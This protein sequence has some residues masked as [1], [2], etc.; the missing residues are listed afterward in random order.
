MN[1]VELFLLGRTL[2]KIG[3]QAMPQPKGDGARGSVRT[4]LVVLGDVVAHPGTTVSEVAARTGLPQSQVS[5]AVARL[6]STGSVEGASD[7]ADRRRRLIRPAATPSARVAEVRA[8]TI[9]DAL[10]AALADPDPGVVGEVVAALEVLARH[11]THEVAARV[12]DVE[13][14]AGALRSQP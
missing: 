3:E 10:G 4:V 5:T 7:P 12:R 6:E 14:P 9:D 13:A 11:L 8:A 2:M 1:G